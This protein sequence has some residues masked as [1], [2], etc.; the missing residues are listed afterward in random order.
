MFSTAES[1]R[2][3]QVGF[4]RGLRAGKLDRF[5]ADFLGFPRFAAGLGL[6]VFVVLVVALRLVEH[7]LTG[8]RVVEPKLLDGAVAG[9][10]KQWTRAPEF[11]R[12]PR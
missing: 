1:V 11:S 12:R 6:V 5:V 7:Q 9:F 4:S 3:R 2:R 8:F 10:F